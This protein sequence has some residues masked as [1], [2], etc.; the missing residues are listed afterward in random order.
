MSRARERRMRARVGRHKSPFFSLLGSRH[1]DH[2]ERCVGNAYI[3]HHVHTRQTTTRDDDVK[4]DDDDVK[5][6]DVVR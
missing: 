3:Y 6:D 2:V 5:D 1:H 4:D